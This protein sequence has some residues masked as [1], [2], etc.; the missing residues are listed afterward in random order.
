VI[1]PDGVEKDGDESGGMGQIGANAPSEANFAETMSIV[2]AHESI[3][4]T[5]NSGALAGLDN[6]AAQPGEGSTAEQGKAPGSALLICAIPTRSEGRSF[7][8]ACDRG[9]NLSGS[10]PSN[11]LI[12]GHDAN[13]VRPVLASFHQILRHS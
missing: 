7:S 10:G 12:D 1:D 5:A 9:D 13:V 11:C 6:G 8:L 2:E 3:Q 4:V